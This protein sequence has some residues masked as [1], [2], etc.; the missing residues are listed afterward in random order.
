MIIRFKEVV[1]VVVV[2]NAGHFWSHPNPPDSTIS[3]SRV[4]RKSD[5]AACRFN[6]SNFPMDW[7]LRR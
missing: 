6:A 1:L 3:D 7:P 2:N 5:R 4:V